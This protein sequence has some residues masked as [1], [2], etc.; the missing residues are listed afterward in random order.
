MLGTS[1][2]INGLD[3]RTIPGCALWLDAARDTTPVGSYVTTLPDRS[4]NG[5]DM[6][7]TDANTMT[8]LKSGPQ[9]QAVYNFSNTRAT[10]SNFSWQTSF[11]QFAVVQTGSGQF[12]VS[13]GN[14][15]TYQNYTFSGNW[16]LIYVGQTFSTDDSDSTLYQ[17]SIFN[18]TPQGVTGWQLWCIGYTAGSSTVKNYTLNGIP[19]TG[20][21]GT[22]FSG[23][24]DSYPLYI[25]GNLGSAVDTSLVAEFIHF[26]SSLTFDQCQQ[27][28]GY[29]AW[30]W[31]LEYTPAVTQVPA[32][33]PTTATGCLLWLDGADH[34]TILNGTSAATTSGTVT[35]WLDKS[36]NNNTAT[37][38]GTVAT[39]TLA[40]NGINF[41]GNSYMSVPGLAN[42]LANTPFVVFAVE[43]YAGGDGRA[44]FGDGINAGTNAT[45]HIL[46]RNSGD[47]TMAFYANDLDY[48]VSGTGTMRL[49]TFYL[50]ASTNRNI[51]LNGNLVATHTNSTRLTS[52][53]LPSVG[54]AEGDTN[55]YNGTISELIVFNVDIGIPAIQQM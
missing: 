10:R 52:F 20:G 50:P 32:V 12:L 54:R 29:L 35:S 1:K 24:Q 15:S 34:T 23:L 17:T 21:T 30:K 28:E 18:A 36:G 31:G 9:G 37:T 19:R 4:G 43:T 46:Y 42:T 33:V 11:T 44:I 14:G 49:W 48:S 53:Q 16:E 7:P 40:T 41:T 47:I 22:P 27:V 51:R 5:N 45:L 38:G 39:T 6:V 55:Y 2:S 8:I 26:N 25:N 3:V 13:N